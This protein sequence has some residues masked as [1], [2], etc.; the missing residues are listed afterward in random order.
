MAEL[1]SGGQADSDSTRAVQQITNGHYGDS[2]Q[3]Y[4]KGRLTSKAASR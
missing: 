2:Y 3:A 1:R 4:F